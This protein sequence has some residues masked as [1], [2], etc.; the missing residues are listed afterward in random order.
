MK[1]QG[2]I[3]LRDEEFREFFHFPDFWTSRFA[4]AKYWKDDNRRRT[5]S[6]DK[7][8]WQML[9]IVI[10]WIDGKDLNSYKVEDKCLRTSN[11]TNF[12]LWNYDPRIMKLPE[13]NMQVGVAALMIII[14]DNPIAI[15]RIFT[16][17]F[18]EE[19]I[20]DVDWTKSVNMVH[21][22]EWYTIEPCK[23]DD[24]GSIRNVLVVNCSEEGEPAIVEIKGSES[25]SIEPGSFSSLLMVGNRA[26]G[27]LRNQE[28]LKIDM[29]SY[30]LIAPDGQP[31]LSFA[32][33]GN[34][35]Y[36]YVTKDGRV[37]CA[38][39][40]IDLRGFSLQKGE[41]VVH[42][43]VKGNGREGFVL[44][45]YR[46]LLIFNTKNIVWGPDIQLGVTFAQYDRADILKIKN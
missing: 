1:L 41:Q 38:L 35:G 21:A 10:N 15:D 7:K 2:V 5:F 46:R 43:G 32:Q 28:G 36:A 20:S 22:G 37:K 3:I 23:K 12:V 8:I 39:S 34:G 25:V 29:T 14:G 11:N 42:V 9:D 26:V 6:D 44:T 33:C 30:T 24:N 16:Y 45:S 19:G 4:F 18:A 40:E 27:I 17:L 31:V 13:H